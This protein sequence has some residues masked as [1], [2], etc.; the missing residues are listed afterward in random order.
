MQLSGEADHV[1]D[2]RAGNRR[3]EHLAVGAEE[4]CLVATL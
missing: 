4:G 1:G 2:A 3:H